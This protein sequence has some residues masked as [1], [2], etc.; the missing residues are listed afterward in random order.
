MLLFQPYSGEGP[1]WKVHEADN[2]RKRLRNKQLFRRQRE[3]I[4]RGN[5][6][7]LWDR[8][9]GAPRSRRGGRRMDS[10]C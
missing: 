4:V 6:P 10:T 3:E 7:E 1:I 8:R 5:E 9:C 2:P